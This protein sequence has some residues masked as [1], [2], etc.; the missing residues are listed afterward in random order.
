ML[1]VHQLS[2]SFGIDTI[3][4]EVS[5]SLNPG[6]RLAL[7]GPNGCGK[8]TLLRILAGIETPDAGHFRLDPPGLALG[9][10]PQGFAFGPDDSLGSFLERMEGDLPGLS[11]R[12][13]QLAVE[14]ARSPQ[15]P[16]LQRAY[17]E[18][19]KRLSAASGNAGSGPAVLAGLGL[20]ELPLD[21]PTARLSVSTITSL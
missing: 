1:T 3:F 4:E 6:D 2:K 10:L 11:S 12:L 5:F 14:L 9:Y 21:M 20:S 8:T 19:L 18:T 16:A 17:D 7:V 13:E 15:Q